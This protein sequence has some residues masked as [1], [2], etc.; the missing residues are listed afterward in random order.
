MKTTRIFL[1]A[2][3]LAVTASNADAQ[4]GIMAGV[5]FASVSAQAGGA[6]VSTDGRTGFNAGVFAA[7]GGIVGFAGGLFYSQKGF[8]VSGNEVKLDYLE[9]PLMLRV[10]FLMLRAYGG[11]NLAFELSCN[12]DSESLVSCSDDTESFDFGW[13]VGVGGT[14]LFFN[15]DVAYIYG[16]TNISKVEGTSI[17]NRV[18]QVDLG[19]G[20]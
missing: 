4:I 20:I 2:A 3:I 19:L 6:D 14:L 8:A 11:P 16:T 7:K 1:A 9:I 12:S 10:K 13:K 17:K 5:N 15:L 18:I